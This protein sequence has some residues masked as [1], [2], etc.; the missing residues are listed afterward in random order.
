MTLT[1]EEHNAKVAKLKAE[2]DAKMDAYVNARSKYSEWMAENEAF[3]QKGIDLA[4]VSDDAY[5]QQSDAFNAYMSA[6][7]ARTN[8]TEAHFANTKADA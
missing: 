5:W 2:Y 1:L 8:A 3:Q 6:V 4:T 7:E